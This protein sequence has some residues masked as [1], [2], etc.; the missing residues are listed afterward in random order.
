MLTYVARSIQNVWITTLL[1]QYG[2]HPWLDCVIWSLPIFLSI[3]VKPYLENYTAR[4]LIT[5]ATYIDIIFLFLLVGAGGHYLLTLSTSIETV[6]NFATFP[7]SFAVR[8]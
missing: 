5:V 7:L 8:F 1:M 3:A 4:F 6:F 2:I